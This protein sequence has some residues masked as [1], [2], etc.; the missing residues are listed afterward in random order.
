M[1][2]HFTVY[3]LILFMYFGTVYSESHHPQDFLKSI[4]GSKDEGEQIY[5]HYCVNCHAQ[6]PLIPLGAPRIG[7]EEDWKS[8]LKQGFDILFLHTD[9]GFNAMPSRGGCFECTDRQL[10]LAIISMVPKRAQ[11]GLLT[12]LEDYKKYK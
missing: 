4:A 11:K 9:E 12:E 1:R 7:Q 5:S 3:V 6:K 8:R 2:T 10:A